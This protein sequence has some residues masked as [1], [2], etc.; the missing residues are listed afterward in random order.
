MQLDG[1]NFQLNISVAKQLSGTHKNR[2]F[3]TI[4]NAQIATFITVRK[5]SAAEAK[6]II[7]NTI[8][9]SNRT[10]DGSRAEQLEDLSQHDPDIIC[11]SLINITNLRRTVT[12]NNAISV[13]PFEIEITAIM[14]RSENMITPTNITPPNRPCPM[15]TGSL[16]TNSTYTILTVPRNIPGNHKPNFPRYL[17]S[18]R[19]DFLSISR[20]SSP[21]SP[22][23]RRISSSET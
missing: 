22:R 3:A 9:I 11:I 12:T 18:L 16:T 8:N 13:V 4:I 21:R 23:L 14:N 5:I 2:V 19:A 1:E 10:I 20:G 15:R 7:T 6:T 17:D